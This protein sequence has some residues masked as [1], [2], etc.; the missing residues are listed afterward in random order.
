VH[1]TGP[2]QWWQASW[3]EAPRLAWQHIP[4][5]DRDPARQA[6]FALLERMREPDGTLIRR[7][8]MA[9]AT[10]VCPPEGMPR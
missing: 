1:Y 4:D 8:E 7:V 9:F 6:A 2:R 3:A 5:A 10:A